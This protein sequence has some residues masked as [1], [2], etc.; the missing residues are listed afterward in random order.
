MGKEKGF[1]LIE[2]MI[3]VSIIGILAAI[4][5]PA[6]LAYMTRAANNACLGEAKGYTMSVM[7][8]LTDGTAV[9]PVPD[10]SAC[11]RI[12]DANSIPNLSV[13]SV[14][15]AYPVSPGDEGTSCNLSA[16]T[17]CILDPSVSP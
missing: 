3:V 12:T 17:S 11:A 2:L 15:D 10:Q 7:V 8:A 6:Y 5:I 16:Q 13:S 1:T 14:I 4:S 9:I